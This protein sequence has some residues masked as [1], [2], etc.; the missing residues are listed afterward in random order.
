MSKN[1]QHTQTHVTALMAAAGQGVVA[2][3]EQLLA[4]GA[5]VSLKASNGWTAKDFALHTAKQAAVNV[6]Q[7]YQ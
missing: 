5:D 3:I 6:L 1:F 2:V 4:F 7:A